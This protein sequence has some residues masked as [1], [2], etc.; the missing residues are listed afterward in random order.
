MPAFNIWSPAKWDLNGV[1]LVG[2]C[3]LTFSGIWS[4]FPHY[5]KKCCRGWPP[6]AKLSGS[7]L[8]DK[9]KEVTIV[10]E[11]LYANGIFHKVEQS[12]WSIVCF[13]GWQV[14]I[15]TKHFLIFSEKRFVCSFVIV[16]F[17]DHTRLFFCPSNILKCRPWWN[18]APSVILSWSSLFA[19]VSV[20]RFPVYIGISMF[21]G[22]RN[23][24]IMFL[25]DINV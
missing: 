19:T 13:E 17:H 3:W 2:Q 11:P 20:Y 7:A 5:Q 1:S 9:Q 4:S 8:V 10:A 21:K 6:L 24:Q 12:G 22:L 25:K 14:I 16:V 18:V 23:Q 15:S